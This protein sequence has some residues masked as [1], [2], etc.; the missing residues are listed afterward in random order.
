MV[1]ISSP[2]LE[3]AEKFGSDSESC[4]RVEVYGSDMRAKILYSTDGS[5]GL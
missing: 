4:F 1:S 3:S 5:A 2:W